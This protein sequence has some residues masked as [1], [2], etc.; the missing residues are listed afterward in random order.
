[1]TPVTSAAVESRTRA[2]DGLTPHP[3]LTSHGAAH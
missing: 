1:M 3:E 2:S